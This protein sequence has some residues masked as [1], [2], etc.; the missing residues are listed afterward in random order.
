MPIFEFKCSKCEDLFEV[1]FKKND[2]ELEMKCP[3][4]GSDDFERVMSSTHYSMSGS[5]SASKAAAQT[6]TCS[7]GSCTT[8]DIPGHQG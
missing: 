2:E 6:R 5:S 8:Y 4:C 1:L 3:K 7:G